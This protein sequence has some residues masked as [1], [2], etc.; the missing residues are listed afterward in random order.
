MNLQQF[1]DDLAISAFG[2]TKSEAH[3]KGVCIKCKRPPVF[4][5]T[6]GPQEYQISGLCDLCFD[7][8]FGRAHDTEKD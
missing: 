4:T 1:K 3:T 7:S 8:M 2:M 6:L 5:S